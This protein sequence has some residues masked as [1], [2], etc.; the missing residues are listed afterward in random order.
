MA[1][2]PKIVVGRLIATV[3]TEVEI[4]SATIKEKGA[5]RFGRPLVVGLIALLIGHQVL[6]KPAQKK[7]AG[8]NRAVQAA[9]ATSKYADEYM[10]LRSQVLA[11]HS[12]LPSMKDKDTW[13]FERVREALGAENLVS[14]TLAPPSQSEISGLSIQKMTITVDLKFP[15]LVSLLYRLESVKPAVHVTMLDLTKGTNGTIGM[16]RAV[17]EVSAVIP[18]RRPG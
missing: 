3:Q 16:N 14:P 2:D 7:L 12:Q 6:Y 1:V 11:A 17:L 13:L 18:L 5:E 10:A 8:L 9:Q 15:Q 4:V